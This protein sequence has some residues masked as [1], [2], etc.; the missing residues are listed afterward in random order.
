MTGELLSV[1]GVAFERPATGGERGFRLEVETLDLSKAQALAVT[2]PSGCG[3]STLVD[4]LAL[5]RRP[6]AAE[7]FEFAGRDIAQLWAT[8]GANACAA[9]RARHIGVVLQTGGLIASLPVWENVTLP[10][11]LVGELDESWCQELLRALDL[12]SLER[13]LPA[14]LSIGQRQRVAIAR[15]LSH[16]P[17]LVLADEPTAALGREHAHA[18][19]GLLLTLTREA[20]AALLIVSH[21]TPL[22]NA[23]GV[24]LIECVI[25]AGVTRLD[26]ACC[27][28]RDSVAVS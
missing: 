16:R 2:G 26:S 1:S 4:L 14:Q 15:A 12:F 19:L 10:Q 3:K 9:I 23:H 28:P 5:L 18:A 22:L 24:P 7:R 17:D 20:G 11:E 8:E 21:D 27:A 6:A 13:R 25:A